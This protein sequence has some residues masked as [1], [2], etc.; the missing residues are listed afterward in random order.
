MPPYD[1]ESKKMKDYQ[2]PEIEIIDFSMAE[3]I[4]TGCYPA[5]LGVESSPF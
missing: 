3:E 5:D 2:K 1:K 4:A